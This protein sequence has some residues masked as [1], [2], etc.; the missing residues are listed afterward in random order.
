MAAGQRR[1]VAILC[2][3]GEHLGGRVAWAGAESGDLHRGEIIDVVAEETGLFKRDFELR[4]EI[5]Q[6]R[7][8]VAR[9]FHDERDVHLLSVAVDQRRGLAGDQRHL[10]AKTAEQGDAHDVGK[11]EALGLFPCRRP[12]ERAVGEDAIDIEGDRPQRN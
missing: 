3:V 11:R 10:E 4:G 7:G 12:N 2:N 1:K 8:L 5:T 6:C 9:A